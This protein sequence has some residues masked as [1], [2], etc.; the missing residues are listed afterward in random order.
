MSARIAL[1]LTAAL[2][3][4]GPGALGAAEPLPQILHRL[5]PHQ[6]VAQV[7]TQRQELQLSEAQVGSLSALEA[8]LRT[9]PHR[10]I[11]RGGKPHRTRHVPMTT[12]AQAYQQVLALVTPEQQDRLAT[13]FQAPAPAS[14]TARPLALPHGRP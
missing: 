7:L 14:G 2:L 13:L 9:E 3:L 10:Y 12:R 11:H 4:S 1:G 6:V 5:R 8:A